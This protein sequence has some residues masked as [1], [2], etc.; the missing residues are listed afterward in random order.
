MTSK[1]RATLEQ[2]IKATHCVLETKQWVMGIGH[3]ETTVWGPFTEEEAKRFAEQQKEHYLQNPSPYFF[4]EYEV[5][6]LNRYN[7]EQ[8]TVAKDIVKYG[9]TKYKPPT[10]QKDYHWCEDCKSWEEA[11]E[12]ERKKE[13]I[14]ENA[15][16]PAG[17]SCDCWC[18]VCGEG[19]RGSHPFLHD[20][21]CSKH[22]I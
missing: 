17:T 2:I 10:E 11:E 14:G 1:L 19:K 15:A 16:P 18:S 6:A 21:R 12:A 20:F 7:P 9:V 22:N 8:V 3:R 4:F 13:I 5:A